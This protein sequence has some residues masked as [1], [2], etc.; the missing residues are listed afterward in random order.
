[1]GIIVMYVL[2]TMA[3]VLLE[4]IQPAIVAGLSGSDYNYGGQNILVK[5]AI[6]LA[7]EA[8]YQTAYQ[9][10]QEY[11]GQYGAKDEQFKAQTPFTL[12]TQGSHL[13]SSALSSA[14]YYATGGPVKDGVKKVTSYVDY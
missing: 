13:F 3:S 6:I 5:L 11:M 14:E 4:L 9:I 12:L 8:A 7:L 10:S 2:F 1:M